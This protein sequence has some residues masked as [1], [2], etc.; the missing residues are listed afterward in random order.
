[1]KFKKIML[2]SIILLAILTVGAVSAN[3]DTD[4]N[5]TL[6]VDDV[7]ETVDVS[8]DEEGI[9]EDSDGVIAS[10]DSDVLADDEEEQILE[11]YINREFS[12][13]NDLDEIFSEV[14]VPEGTQGNVTISING[15]VLYNKA[16][17][18][19]DESRIDGSTYGIALGGDDGNFIF[20]GYGQDDMILF[21]F[22]YENG[23]SLTR[24]YFINLEDNTISFDN[25]DSDSPDN[26]ETF[27]GLS[28][29]IMDLM[30]NEPYSVIKVSE[31]PEGIDDYFDIRLQKD[32]EEPITTPWDINSVDRDRAGYAMWNIEQL[33]IHDEGEYSIS[34][35]FT[36]GGV[37]KIIEVGSVDIGSGDDDILWIDTEREF[38]INPE[39]LDE[40]FATIRVSPEMNGRIIFRTDD[41]TLYEKHLM[42][43][44]GEYIEGDFYN[45]ILRDYDHFIFEN[46]ND[47]DG[48]QFAFIDDNDGEIACNN[49]FIHF[50]DDNKVSF[51]KD[52]YHPAEEVRIDVECDFDSN[53]EGHFA[54]VH[55]PE[56]ISDGKFIVTAGNVLLLETNVGDDEYWWIEE[57][58][59]LACGIAPKDIDWTK[60]NEGDI[61]TFSFIDE[62]DETLASR[63]F[64]VTINGEQIH[65]DEC[66]SAENF[67]WWIST[68]ECENEDES[69][70][71]EVWFHDVDE[72]V[73]ILSIENSAGDI[74]SYE[75]SVE[76]TDNVHWELRDLGIIDETGI[77]T[78]NLTYSN[79]GRSIALEE[80]HIFALT[81]F[82]YIICENVYAEYP[83][84]V[85]RFYCEED[86][87]GEPEYDVK[88]YV[89]GDEK[90]FAEMNPYRW[91]LE[92]LE[93]D[94]ADSY[95]ITIEVYKEDV[96]VETFSYTL[97]V[98]DDFDNILLY[99]DGLSVESWEIDEPILFLISPEEMI[100]Q[101]VKMFI[102]NDYFDEFD[103]ESIM[104]WTLEDLEID[105][106]GGYNIQLYD[107][108][109]E[110]ITD[111][112]I[113]VWCIDGSKFRTW[114]WGDEDGPL[115]NDTEDKV[116]SVETPE[117]KEGNIIIIIDGEEVINWEIEDNYNEWTIEDLE[118]T[119]VKEYDVTVK[120]LG[121]EEEEILAETTLNVLE[122]DYSTFRAI[123]D[124]ENEILKL[125]CSEEGTIRITVLKYDDEEEG[126]QV[127]EDEF[128]I[129]SGD[130][131]NWKEWNLEDLEFKY[132]N[133]Y[134]EFCVSVLNDEDEEVYSYSKGY[135]V[136]I[137]EVEPW[138]DEN[139]LY[140][141]YE[142]AVIRVDVPD[143]AKQG[144]L[145]LVMDDNVKF[146]TKIFPGSSYE[147][148]LKTLDISFGGDYDITL[149]FFDGNKN[150]TL[151]EETLKVTE[152]NNDTFRSKFSY[153]G[154]TIYFSFFCCEDDD[155][156]ITVIIHGW[157]PDEEQEIVEEVNYT[158]DDTF[159]NKW[160]TI[161]YGGLDRYDMGDEGYVEVKLNGEDKITEYSMEMMERASLLVSGFERNSD[162]NIELPHGDF[163]WIE[164]PFGRSIENC[165]VNIS[166]GDYVYFKKLSELGLYEWAGGYRYSVTLDDLDSFETL[167]DKDFIS[168]T[169]IHNN[170][171]LIDRRCIEKTDDELIIHT[172]DDQWEGIRI[173][174]SCDN[175][176]EEEEDEEDEGGEEDE[177]PDE[178]EVFAEIFVPPENNIADADILV[179]SGDKIIFS[180]TLADLSGTFDYDV[181][182]YLYHIF[183]NDLNLTG[184]ADKDIV[185]VAFISDGKILA[186]ESTIYCFD[187][188]NGGFHHYTEDLSFDVNYGALD[189]PEFGMGEHDGTFIRLSIPDI[190]NI[191]EGTIEIT[192]D[193]GT[194]LFSKSLSSFN[195]TS[196]IRYKVDYDDYGLGCEYI[197]MANETIYG[198]FPQ[199]QNMTFS[200]K[201]GENSISRKGIRSGDNL[202]KI[203]TPSD[204]L[205][206]FD[207]VISE[208]VLVNGTDYA[209]T[210][211]GTVANRQSI[212]ID[213][214][215]GYFSVYVNGVRIEDLGRINR[216]DG[217][218]ELYLTN[219]C[220][221]N[222][223]T[224]HLNIYLSDIGI[225][226]NGVYDIR[227]THTPEAG[228][229]KVYAETEV[230][231]TNVT[232]AS[233][234]KANYENESVEWLTGY[235]V[236]PIL[237]YLDTYYG[238]INATTGVITV[239]NSDN[240]TILEKNIND[241]TYEEGRYVLRYSDF[242][243]KDFGDKI[244][245][246]YSDGNERNG[247]TSLDVKWRDVDPT[248]FNTTVMD[249][250]ND[251]YGNFINLNIPE[252]INTGQII[253]TIKFKNNHGSNISNMSV[254]TD[255]DSK[256]VYRFNVADIKANYGNDFALALYDLGF[257]EDNGNY[258]IDVK[259]TADNVN[260]L[261]V[262]SSALNVEFLKDIII[263]INETSR[264]AH[265]EPF[266]TVRV[267][268]PVTAY[269]ELYIDGKFYDKKSFERGLITF[270][271]SKDWTVGTHQAEVRVLNSEFGS[272]LNSSAVEF[273]TL[274][275]SED[276]TVEVSDEF[277]ANEHVIVYITVPKAG[278]VT[279][280][281]DKAAS[282]IRQL[283][284]GSNQIDLGILPYGNHRLWIEYEEVLD[285]GNVTFYSNYHSFFVSDDGRWLIFPDPLVLNDDD[286][287]IIDL[288]SDSTGYVLIYI[289]GGLVKNATLVNGHAEYVVNESIFTDGLD[290]GVLGAS[291]KE[292]YGKHTYKIFY[293]GDKTHENITREGEF[294]VAYIFKDDLAYEYPYKESYDITVTLPGDANG[295]VRLTVNN[296][297][298]ISQVTDGKAT[299]TV[300]NLPLGEHDVFIEYLGGDYPES[301]YHAVLNIS[302]YGVIGE[303]SDSAR[304]VSLLLPT[305][306]TGNLTVF[307]DNMGSKL[308]YSV[309]LVNGKAVLDL[310]NLPVDIYSLRAVYN[311]SDYQVRSFYT[312][313]R[314]MPKVNITQGVIM[315]DD[316]NIFLD[317]DNATGDVVISMDGLS[318][319]VMEVIDGKVNYTFSTEGYSQGNHTV[320]FL[321]FGRSFDG[322]VFFEDDGKTKIGY[323][324]L[325]L[326]QKTTGN[327]TS[328]ED[329]I[330]VRIYREDGSLAT[331]AEK[332]VT[333]YVNG[334]KYAVVQVH[335]GIARLDIS[336]FKNGNYL[337]SWTYSGD[338]KYASSS[339]ESNV[340][341]NHNDL[342]VAKDASI[343]Y[344][345]NKVYSVTVYKA[346][347]SLAKGVKVT[348]L[349]NNK[350]FK[351]VNTNSK[352]VAS[353]VIT[354]NPGTYKI[355][356]K[357]SSAS[358]TKTLKV[359]HVVS[360]KKVK[361][362]RSAK[363][364][365]IKATLKK[366]NG[367]YL[368]SKKVTLKFN[369]KKYT[370]KTNKKGVAKFT[371]KSKVLKKLKAGKK[372]KYQ[373]T[374][375]KDTVK[376][377]VKV[378]K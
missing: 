106:D 356:S 45:I 82:S 247:E 48:F 112:W 363:K 97:N 319:V 362:K 353:V 261:N 154:D 308:L 120:Y 85:I 171:K 281:M 204:V 122:Y 115:Y 20:D 127:F 36:F 63:E 185:K 378:K 262:T 11:I 40:V 19:F 360:L 12:T 357:T 41:D 226:E 27:E 136:G 10:S 160:T 78:V 32:G 139:I 272:I 280:Q 56:D 309:A 283:S 315:G 61:V 194:V 321:Y 184:L 68:H 209:I 110:Q 369:G 254:D 69:F 338:K 158:I 150:I 98:F 220:S 198:N 163:L 145:Y 193:D 116:I 297:P 203:I 34:F 100:G 359:T 376:M 248:D 210:I 125:Y 29:F 141:D 214:G 4:F 132:D 129:G 183:I 161:N 260:V 328:T 250:I 15:N 229:M 84:D 174:L 201:Y 288:G 293:S 135:Q 235:G 148:N 225:T 55:L 368:K 83:F 155:G 267:F 16:I 191:T 286:T 28:V 170:G 271:S 314:V 140:N 207:I 289:D 134:Y 5:E 186:E 38:S 266:A 374:Y 144:I 279:V 51:E 197:I 324:L 152:F 131:G 181:G 252:L 327:L 339:G 299:F 361:V 157:D 87:E 142:G 169:F 119:E 253:V 352:G 71:S 282:E 80:N 162:L 246:K 151:S 354:K 67:N 348:F 25:D 1:M 212:Y 294:T 222:E 114:I 153:I 325:I 76:E 60:L 221:N 256:A 377:K 35:I 109:N 101:H 375:K 342:I 332:Y 66:V 179:S 74:Q 373:A 233:N 219:L 42:D 336:N 89:E 301:S 50:L 238:D 107:D 370:A 86:D 103:V 205:G 236:D 94:G 217:E 176:D 242:E 93:I 159:K 290:S 237:M 113:N 156:I 44:P 46:L 17:S 208:D 133:R 284:E 292:K 347:G 108:S 273:D 227:V 318:P 333:F 310:T 206:I 9:S 95:D 166:C 14:T 295:Q 304:Y 259:F 164:L 21:S 54:W 146:T 7:Q 47:G 192:L 244:T 268:E 126:E 33:Q 43:F 344:S 274:A 165:T 264:Y 39:D 2:V 287:I 187:G 355:T 91:N 58:K 346:D 265:S 128:A 180:R 23:D 211:D 367:K 349:I 320:N 213:I 147:W 269:G 275:H 258:D 64:E 118:M 202:V 3:D 24:V 81:K 326:P 228:D 90:P 149:I 366:V 53:D 79:N 330:E 218:T 6:T 77:Y 316:A 137:P 177:D 305:N 189:D 59:Y 311:G 334:M 13:T 240:V 92:D 111:A 291:N 243:N 341:V 298:Q 30:I 224:Q 251:Y 364:L 323:D 75:R 340:N 263:T 175:E 188:E 306:A 199:N 331:D 18:D 178:F 123:L 231:S 307:N 365:T 257:Y 124:K 351:T 296:N 245:V 70:I 65:L 317:L 130:L 143:S 335:D 345:S 72:G 350:V 105:H 138:D 57:E 276:V 343:L 358:T 73:L 167:S 26:Y 329:Y 313:F 215:G 117:G 96:L 104:S 37:E 232:L 234:V 322:N 168:V 278:N 121:D 277:G 52:E 216:Y 196:D 230:L 190:L 223:G 200:F 241:L 8:L 312:S 303:Y 371:I 173:D 285:D 102:D 31:W 337:I 182:T 239:L 195:D 249:D 88:V 172:M 300:G 22:L 302:H 62:N 49:Y 255:F 270:I 372:V 99:T